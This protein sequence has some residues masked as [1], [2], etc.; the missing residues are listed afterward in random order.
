MATRVGTGNGSNYGAASASSIAGP[1][2]S[3]TTGNLLVLHA[4]WE[5]GTPTVSSI[6][7]T[8]GNT[9]STIS[10]ATYAY[11]G[12]RNV[13]AYA[14]NITG[15]ASN[16]V[17]VNLSGAAAWRDI[18]IEEFAGLDTSSPLDG[19]VQTAAGVDVDPYV[20]PNI[21]TTSPGLVFLAVGDFNSVSGLSGTPG[22]P[23]FSVGFTTGHDCSCFYLLSGS[24]QTVTPGGTAS[25][26]KTN[27]RAMAQAFKDAPIASAR[28]RR[29]VMSGRQAVNRAS[30]Y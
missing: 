29:R 15:H 19:T 23:D 20:T 1:S 10:S 8:A 27:W 26:G 11:D 4:K 14:K 5:S 21:T 7:D 17:T 30:T 25:T 18:L 24:A 6:T 22:V 28:D 3:T 9:W 2:M 12:A 16:V 13:M